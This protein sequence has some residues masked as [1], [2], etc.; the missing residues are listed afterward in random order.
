MKARD[1]FDRLRMYPDLDVDIVVKVGDA[2]VNIRDIS[3]DANNG[4]LII[5]LKNSEDNE[6]N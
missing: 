1:F 3:C 4:D 2:F 5:Y 6:D